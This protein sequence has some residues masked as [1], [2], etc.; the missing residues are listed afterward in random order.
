MG[1]Y[2]NEE[3]FKI[4]KPILENKEF[5]KMGNIRHHGIT[6]LDHSIRVAY[7]SYLITKKL[8]LDYKETTKAAL[9]HDFFLEEVENKNAIKKL[10]CHPKYAVDNAKKHFE[11]SDKQEDIIKTHMFP[12]TFIPPKYAESWIVDLID[13]IASIYERSYSVKKEIQAATIFIFV[14]VLNII[15]YK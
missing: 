12:V 7:F 4:I 8:H 6:R 15:K 1:K 14:L 5:Q 3:F 13:D 2:Q 11:I 9:L 10:R